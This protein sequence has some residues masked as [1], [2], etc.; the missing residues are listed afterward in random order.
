M[1]F[2]LNSGPAGWSFTSKIWKGLESFSV[3]PYK[4]ILNQF[5]IKF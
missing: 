1:P 3:S 2:L 4:E 5:P